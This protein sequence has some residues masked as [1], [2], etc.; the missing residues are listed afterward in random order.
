MN[1]LLFDGLAYRPLHLFYANIV[2]VWSSYT[3]DR[4]IWACKSDLPIK[5]N[6]TVMWDEFDHMLM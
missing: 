4:H 2:M 6:A 5:H 1:I 3:L